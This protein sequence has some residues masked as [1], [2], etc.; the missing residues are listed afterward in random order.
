MTGIKISDLP[1][2]VAPALSDVFPI[3]Q[4]AVTYKESGSQ[5]L[6]LFQANASGTWNINISGNAATVTTNANLTGDVTSVGNATTYNNFVPLAKGGLNAALVASNGGIFY[7]TATA[8]ALL[9]GTATAGQI[10]RSGASA[11]P[12]WST[13]TYPSTAGT[14]G[15]VLT[16][17][18][19]N[20]ISSAATGGN[21]L[22]TKGDLF[23][24][25]TVDARLPVGVT[26]GQY[27]QVN[28][29]AATGLAWSTATLP[30]TATNVARI[31][32]SNATNWVETTSTFADTYAA[33]GFLYANGANNVAGL[34]TAN[35]GL[36]V[37]S[38]TGVPSILA[39]PGSTG[40][41][42]QSNAAAA[43]SWSTAV[44]PATAGANGNVL[45]SDGTNW[46]SSVP[47]W[48]G[49]AGGT[50]AGA[51]AMGANKIDSSYTPIAGDN[52]TNKT[53]VDTVVG[54]ASPLTTKG[55]IYG[56]STIPTRLA[57]GADGTIPQALA[58]AAD[59]TG[60]QWSTAT[61]PPTAGTSGNV[62]QSDGTNWTS[63][64]PAATGSADVE[65]SL[66]LGGM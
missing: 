57:V 3:D 17:D 1:A 42:L 50:M 51:I 34:A 13:A 49:L 52:L 31:L 4:G 11:A 44:F 59:G 33:S 30:A 32:R 7:S 21:P 47:V 2:V 8:G 38:N 36:P 27:L 20:W 55:D 10:L 63:A 12:T 56:F 43:P 26:N 9:S 35:N 5:L 65:D 60:L 48:L 28:S 66:F 19:T 61:Y 22:T 24:F 23:T 40:N 37:T 14:S 53:Y 62:L 41:I 46:A 29:G 54:V 18:G 25:T 6:S 15:N 16:S 58:A 45:I 39:G 64:V